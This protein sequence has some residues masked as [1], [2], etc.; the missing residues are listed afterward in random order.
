M[1]N[2]SDSKKTYCNDDCEEPTLAQKVKG[3][4]V[5]LKKLA[6]R[7]MG[8]GDA[9]VDEDT[10]NLRLYE[11]MKCPFRDPKSKS[12]KCIKCGCYMEVKTWISSSECPEGIW[13]ATEIKSKG[14]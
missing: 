4:F 14:E 9:F 8:P 3:L 11:C 10:R 7:M 2:S 5:D 6:S 13:K 1:S 12:L